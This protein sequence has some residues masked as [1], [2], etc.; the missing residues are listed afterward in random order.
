MAIDGRNT[1][2]DQIPPNAP[3]GSIRYKAKL[4]RTTKSVENQNSD[5]LALPVKSTY[6]LKKLLIAWPKPIVCGSSPKRFGPAAGFL[7]A[8]INPTLSGTM[9]INQ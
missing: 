8:R 3:V 5:R 4:T 7:K 9:M 2:S 6:F 1:A